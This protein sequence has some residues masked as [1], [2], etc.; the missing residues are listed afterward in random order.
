MGFSR[1]LNV[2]LIG[3]SLRQSIRKETLIQRDGDRHIVLYVHAELWSGS[4]IGTVA[5]TMGLS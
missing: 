5:A 4:S 2:S 1:C 3:A